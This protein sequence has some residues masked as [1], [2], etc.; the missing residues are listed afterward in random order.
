MV[1]RMGTNDPGR[2]PIVSGTNGQHTDCSGFA[3]NLGQKMQLDSI[4]IMIPGAV[5]DFGTGGA[6]YIC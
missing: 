2:V 4:E 6:R 3:D 1:F 5:Q